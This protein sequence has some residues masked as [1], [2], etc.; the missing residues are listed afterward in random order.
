MCRVRYQSIADGGSVSS[1]S[2]TPEWSLCRTDAAGST[3]SCT[4]GCAMAGGRAGDTR[5]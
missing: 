3:Y 5:K 1:D 2:M 4:F